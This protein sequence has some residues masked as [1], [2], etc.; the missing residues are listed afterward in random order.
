MTHFNEDELHA[1]R[2]FAEEHWDA[3]RNSCLDTM[4][5]DEFEDLC[6]KLGLDPEE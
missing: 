3:F 1:L 6:R 5:E 2:R 4:S